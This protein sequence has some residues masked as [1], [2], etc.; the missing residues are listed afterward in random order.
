MVM[1][2]TI[3]NNSMNNKKIHFYTY[4]DSKKYKVSKKHLIHLAKLSGLF[5]K[6]YSFS[7]NDVPKKEKY[8]YNLIFNN[9]RGGGYWVWKYLILEKLL[10]NTKEGDI[11]VYCD[12]G[13]SFNYHAKDRFLEYIDM[14]N[15]SEFGNFR[16]ESKKHHIEKFWT[17]KEIFQYFNVEKDNK[18]TDTT[19]LL[20]GYLLFKNCDH[21]KNLLNIFFDLLSKDWELISDKYNNN[22]I[23]NFLEN[24]HDQSIWSVLT[25]KYGGEIIEN[26]SFFNKNEENQYNYPFLSVR[27]Y[28]HGKKD[29]IKFNLNFRNMKTT[30]VYF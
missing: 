25:K 24:R 21:T 12:S 30:P 4:G 26:E 10:N 19:Q 11:I 2:G 5:N 20:G 13:S 28:G 16:M 22:Q 1:E 17:T 23:P 18:V 27:N 29:T 15:H 8:P 6:L 14:L 7:F 3:L 9:D